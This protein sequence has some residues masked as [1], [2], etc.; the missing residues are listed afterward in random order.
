MERHDVLV[1]PTVAEPAP[2]L[3]YL[4]TDLPFDTKF[5]RVRS[6]AAFTPIYN[7]SG[8]PAISLP[9]GRSAAGLPIGVQFAAGHGRDRVLLE[10]AL[11]IEAT[12]P[13]EAIAPRRAWVRPA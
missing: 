3:G 9:L 7:A 8:A 10:L 4:A 13:W 1:S 2:P 12:R 11:S 6:F 5:A